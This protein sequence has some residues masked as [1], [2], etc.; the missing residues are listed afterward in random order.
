MPILVNKIS[1]AIDGVAK[2]KFKC[3]INEQEYYAADITVKVSQLSPGILTFYLT[4]TSLFERISDTS[5]DV[6]ATGVGKRI[7]VEVATDL[8]K[9]QSI[10]H[11]KADNL[12]GIVR[13]EGLITKMEAQRNNNFFMIK[14][15]AHTF[16]HLMTLGKTCRSYVDKTLAEI[17]QDVV[18]NYQNDIRAVI[19]PTFEE[20][21]PYIVQYCESDYD[22]LKRLASTYGEWMYSDGETFVFGKMEQKDK[23]QLAFLKGEIADFNIETKPVNFSQEFIAANYHKGDYSQKEIRD[24]VEEEPLDHPLINKI[25]ETS[26]DLAHR[27]RNNILVTHV[28]SLDDANYDETRQKLQTSVEAARKLSNTLGY[29]GQTISTRLNIGTPL[30][31]ENNLI[32]NAH[33]RA[34]LSMG[35]VDE[36]IITEVE[37][38]INSD[39]SY[40]NTFKGKPRAMIDKP[41][42][43]AVAMPKCQTCTAKVVENEDPEELGRIKVQFLWQEA[44]QEDDMISPWLRLVQPYAGLDKGFSFI[45][46]IGEQVMVGFIGDNPEKPFVMG[47]IYNGVEKP[48]REWLRDSN[49]ANQ[50]KAIRTANGHTIE[51]HDEGE[52]G[53]I[54]IYDYK[55]ENY[56]L[57]F[58]TDEK[59]IKLESTGNIELYAQNDIIMHAGHDINASAGHDINAT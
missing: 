19:N 59:L 7:E 52:N 40:Y 13:F 56:I 53:Y 28:G 21:I 46:E 54:R 25:K 43:S 55:K 1:I 49:K 33:D 16:D 45:P 3:R 20:S 10:L 31:V 6:C 51:I 15:T 35:G 44:A 30:D 9:F 11:P 42:Y 36:V 8:N 38:N 41:G 26:V 37:H 14:V 22:F 50:V 17:V 47:T 4:S 29:S 34:L 27:L 24:A 5:F 2:E 32:S 48:D 57:T 12:E 23:V 18:D 39:S 58:S